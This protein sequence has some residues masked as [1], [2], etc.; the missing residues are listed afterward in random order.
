MGGDR[1]A[2][3]QEQRATHEAERV[4]LLALPEAER[5]GPRGGLSSW[6]SAVADAVGMVAAIDRAISNERRFVV[7]GASA[8]TA[9]I[10]QRRRRE[11][12]VSVRKGPG[13]LSVDIW[14]W[15]SSRLTGEMRPTNRRIVL[16]ADKLDALI[17][18]LRD[19]RQHV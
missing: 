10:P 12:R 5:L 3:L 13:A 8:T 9:R 4:R 1:L 2:R 7:P 6:K 14:S 17:D 15:A 19:A 11:I 18:A 16:D